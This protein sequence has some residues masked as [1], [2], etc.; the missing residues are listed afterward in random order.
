MK[1]TLSAFFLIT[2]VTMIVSCDGE[3]IAPTHGLETVPVLVHRRTANNGESIPSFEVS[4]NGSD[5]S[6][7]ATTRAICGKI[8]TTA[9]RRSVGDI[10]IVLSVIVD[11]G[12]LCAIIPS[13]SVID[14]DLTISKVNPGSVRVNVFESNGGEGPKFL[15]SRRIFVS[16]SQ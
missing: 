14:Y 16:A 13:N 1:S 6:L 2:A 8:V 10:D 11:P 15:G 12:A 5:V 9:V 3:P 7:H 4:S